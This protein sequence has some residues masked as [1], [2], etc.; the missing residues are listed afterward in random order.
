MEE[1]LGGEA[2]GFF[3]ALGGDPLVGLRVNTLKTTA[4][5]FAAGSPFELERVAWCPEGFVVPGESRP[6][7][8]PLHAAGV[9]YLQDPAAM[10]ATVLLDPRPGEAIVDLS[11]APGGKASHI[12]A[13]WPERGCWWPTK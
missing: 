3:A 10:A 9:Y 2:A 5:H 13:A 8:H 11:A 1:L 12:A 6:G 7:R 4:E